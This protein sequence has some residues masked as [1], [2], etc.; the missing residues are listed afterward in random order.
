MG[1]SADRD[2][3]GLGVAGEAKGS[4]SEHHAPSPLPGLCLVAVVVMGILSNMTLVAVPPA[5][6][7]SLAAG[8][9]LVDPVEAAMIPSA[10]AGRGD[11]QVRGNGLSGKAV[12]GLVRDAPVVIEGPRRNAK[13]M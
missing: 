2:C 11:E 13:V 1:Q 3:L 6:C 7:C 12:E 10:M 9:S 8:Q 4:N 5:C